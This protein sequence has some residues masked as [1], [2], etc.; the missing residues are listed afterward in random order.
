MFIQIFRNRISQSSKLKKRIA[1][2]ESV[3]RSN[4]NQKEEII[5]EKLTKE[6]NKG[7]RINLKPFSLAGNH[8]YLWI[9]FHQ[10]KTHKR[11]VI[12]EDKVQLDSNQ[13][14]FETEYGDIAIVVEYFLQHTPINRKV[15]ILQTKK[16]KRQGE[17]EIMLHQLYLMQYRPCVEF[18]TGTKH[19]FQG[20]FPSEFSFYHFILNHSVNA[21]FCSSLCSAPIVGDLLGTTETYLQSEL[22]K[23]I[24]QKKVNLKVPPPSQPLRFN[25]LPGTIFNAGRRFRWKLIPKPFERFLLEAAYLFVGT[26]HRE[27][28]AVTEARVSTILA[29]RVVGSREQEREDVD[30]QKWTHDMYD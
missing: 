20:A 8:Y 28:L 9:D 4:L 2:L 1:S 15:S 7:G 16:E 18:P 5:V 30:R 11:P 25:L 6:W 27:V 14:K 10:L 22:K 19:D 23:W 21:Q 26:S 12:V 24:N 17:T 13:L 29:M 3:I